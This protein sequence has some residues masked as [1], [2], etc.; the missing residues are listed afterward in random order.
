MRTLLS[1]LTCLFVLIFASHLSHATPIII[2]FDDNLV[3]AGNGVDIGPRLETDGFLLEA[4]ES[5]FPASFFVPGIDSPLYLGSAGIIPDFANKVSLTRLNSGIF[6]FKSIVLAIGGGSGLGVP[7]KFSG[8]KSD[9]TTV[10]ETIDL[11]EFTDPVTLRVPPAVDTI[12]TLNFQDNFT[13]LV[14]L[15]FFQ[16][17]ELFQV[18]QISLEIPETTTVSEPLLSNLLGFGLFGFLIA[19]GR[20]KK[21]LSL[22]ILQH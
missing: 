17:A 10:T 13:D 21:T 16:G 1:F 6:S 19:F 4:T 20:R 22:M 14:N 5:F 18:D 15:S 2:D 12:I 9:G 7:V 11:P 8:T 3:E